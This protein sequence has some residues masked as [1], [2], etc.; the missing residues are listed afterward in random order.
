MGAVPNPFVRRSRTGGYD[1][2]APDP[3]RSAS[4]EYGAAGRTTDAPSETERDLPTLDTGISVFEEY[5]K[6]EAPIEAAE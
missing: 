6:D 1:S 4:V 3:A 5:G 2:P